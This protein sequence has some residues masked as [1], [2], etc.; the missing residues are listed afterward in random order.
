MS[1][2]PSTIW[3]PMDCPNCKLVN[4]PNAERCDCGYD[5]QTRMIEHSYLTERDKS[6]TRGAGVA[7]T[8]LALLLTFKFAL[9]LTTAVITQHS[10]A[11]GLLMLFLVAVAFV[12]WRWLL[13][14]R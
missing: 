13:R 10:A 8:V 14:A 9:G 12:S 5:F 6:L 2:Q 11:M 7:A 3:L 4:P 1:P